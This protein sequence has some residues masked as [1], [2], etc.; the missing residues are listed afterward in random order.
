M[1]CPVCDAAAEWITP[2]SLD[3]KSIRCPH[4]GDYDISGNTWELEL[5]APLTRKQRDKALNVAKRGVGSRRPRITSY[6]IAP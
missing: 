3:A 1:E 2:P 4:C 5:L 6:V